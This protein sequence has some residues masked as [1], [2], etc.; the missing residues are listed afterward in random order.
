MK[1][2]LLLNPPPIHS[3]N[4]FKCIVTGGKSYIDTVYTPLNLAYIAS[5]LRK[6]INKSDI[7][8]DLLD[9]NA[10]NYNLQQLKKHVI[11]TKPDILI[12]DSISS[13]FVSD[14]YTTKLIKN[15]IPN[16]EIIFTGIF[17]TSNWFTI[18]KEKIIDFVIVGEPE[19]TSLELVKNRIYKISPLHTIKGVV[20]RRND[21]KI[22]KNQKRPLIRN[23]DE[24][25]FPARDMLPL[26]N[27]KQPLGR[28]YPATD[29]KTSRGCIH[30][31]LFCGSK[32]TY[33]RKWRGRSPKNVVDE[34]QEIR[35][36]YKIKEIWVMEDQFLSNRGRALEI[37]NEIIKRNLDISW[38]FNC[39][40]NEV[41]LHLL[42]RL[43][44]AGCHRIDYG[45]ESANDEIRKT[46]RKGI[47]KEMIKNAFKLTKKAGIKTG[48]LV[49]IGFPGETWKTVKET[50]KFIK[51][52]GADI[53]IYHIA[54]PYPGTDFYNLSKNNKW[55]IKKDLGNYNMCECVISYPD[56]TSQDI[57]K[58]L[59]WSITHFYLNFSYIF[60]Q[61]KSINS[62]KDLKVLTRHF[63][64]YS[65]LIKNFYIPKDG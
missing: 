30:N 38:V 61:I 29:I 57:E 53:A 40:V 42:K 31:C 28:Y 20:W 54:T 39:R 32:I 33:S 5:L 4:Y 23:L 62:L 15:I 45:V 49:V 58:A 9:A 41:D 19:F 10:L 55:I 16:I 24:L 51:E 1:K 63:F 8:I 7:S 60:K 22:I 21:K 6:E 56:F 18:M 3:R 65:V 2:I 14:L 48:A 44:K 59:L 50:A 25:P 36:K 47:T 13:S 52:I 43:K 35:E 26:K 34:M 11:K 37:C 27:Y 17:A 12:I 46:L 64:S